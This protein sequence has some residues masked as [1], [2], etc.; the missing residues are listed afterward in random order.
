MVFLSSQRFIHHGSGCETFVSRPDFF[1]KSTPNQRRY[2]HGS[3]TFFTT[4]LPSRVFSTWTD[5][6][7]SLDVLRVVFFGFDVPFFARSTTC[8]GHFLHRSTSFFGDERIE[9]RFFP[10]AWKAVFPTAYISSLF[11]P[12]LINDPSFSREH[13]ESSSFFCEIRP[14]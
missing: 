10:R 12:F 11:F 9:R 6:V 1:A 4:S 5:A 2:L 13:I 7:F 14:F 3:T 8:H